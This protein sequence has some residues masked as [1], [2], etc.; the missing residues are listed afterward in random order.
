VKPKVLPNRKLDAFF[1]SITKLLEYKDYILETT[2]RRVEVSVFLKFGSRISSTS[3][4]QEK[5][6]RENLW[7]L[8]D[9]L[10][11]KVNIYWDPSWDS[12][13]STIL[14][15]DNK[16]V[17]KPDEDHRPLPYA[18]KPHFLRANFFGTLR[19]KIL[20][21]QK[22]HREPPELNLLFWIA[23]FPIFFS[24]DRLSSSFN[25]G[26]EVE[27]AY[28]INAS[29]SGTRTFHAPSGLFYEG[30]SMRLIR[31]EDASASYEERDLHSLVEKMMT[32]FFPKHADIITEERKEK[33]ARSVRIAI[34]K[35]LSEEKLF[36]DIGDDSF[37]YRKV[38][39]TAKKAQEKF[40]HTYIKRGKLG[41]LALKIVRFKAKLS[42]R[43]LGTP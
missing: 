20:T 2:R 18:F 1:P 38:E 43:L 15:I 5:D 25:A 42:D 14:L 31:K 39:L 24:S 29:G 3:A 19:G 4:E 17:I 10:E 9:F 36:L 28:L 21:V 34:Q 26:D 30:L 32:E 16:L 11:N 13:Q 6:I 27:V 8:T 22:L 35:K 7:L 12:I 33:W 23:G 41:Q 40:E 37:I